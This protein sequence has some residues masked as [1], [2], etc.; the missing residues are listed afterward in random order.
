MPVQIMERRAIIAHR[1]AEKP[2]PE[3]APVL[4][5]R[6]QRVVVPVGKLPQFMQTELRE[7]LGDVRRHPDQE[8]AEREVLSRRVP[9]DRQDIAR[10]FHIDD[11]REHAAKFAA[12]DSGLTPRLPPP[13]RVCELKVRKDERTS[14]CSAARVLAHFNPQPSMGA[15]EIRNV[16][17]VGRLCRAP[18][19][20]QIPVVERL[21]ELER[22]PADPLWHRQG[23]GGL[24]QALS[25][26]SIGHLRS[27]QSGVATVLPDARERASIS[28]RVWTDIR[29]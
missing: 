1:S 9:C 20:L 2:T 15:Q 5:A 4:A 28:V 13:I 18:E 22:R 24:R 6:S 11:P 8:R 19:A 29:C 26:G 25:P 12:T 27:P 14:T 3:R 17:C 10:E 7:E 21:D 23:G 16:P